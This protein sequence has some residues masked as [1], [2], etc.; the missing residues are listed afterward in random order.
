MIGYMY[1]VQEENATELPIANHF[2]EPGD[3]GSLVNVAGA[4]M[5]G[6][7]PDQEQAVAVIDAF[8]TPEIQTYFAETTFEYQLIEG[9]EPAEVEDLRGTLVLLA[10]VGAL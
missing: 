9:V 7:G 5:L 2:F 6:D 3:P 8:L 1:E 10:E 4:G